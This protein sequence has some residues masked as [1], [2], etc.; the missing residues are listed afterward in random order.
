MSER[1]S[2]LRG[3]ARGGW[4]RL[5]VAMVLLTRWR[6]MACV[7]FALAALLIT[8]MLG[9]A[10]RDG[11][12]AN[13]GLTASWNAVLSVLG[14]AFPVALGAVI[15]AGGALVVARWN[16]E[17][18][19]RSRFYTNA[20]ALAT[21]VIVEA[22]KHAR[23]L[24]ALIAWLFEYVDYVDNSGPHG[25]APG[26][27]TTEA[28]REAYLSLG[29]LDAGLGTKGEAIYTALIAMD[30]MTEPF[31]SRSRARVPG[32]QRGRIR[33]ID[34]GLFRSDGRLPGRMAIPPGLI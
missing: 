23:Q 31:R 21:N 32:F 28:V 30:V 29:L 5:G 25:T 20:L 26:L 4:P 2:R 13:P 27:H 18:A 3:R 9:W 15:G 22:D 19:R 12:G 8:A 33:E 17:E 16:R 11:L 14:A 1:A 7:L 10:F 34:Q 24:Q 6:L